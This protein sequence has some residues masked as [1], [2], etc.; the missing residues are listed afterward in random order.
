MGAQ[1][2][3]GNRRISGGG[4]WMGMGGAA[5]RFISICNSYAAKSGLTVTDRDKRRPAAGLSQSVTSSRP[6]RAYLLQIEILLQKPRAE[7]RAEKRAGRRHRPAV[8]PRTAPQQ[9]G[10]GPTPQFRTFHPF[11][12]SSSFHPGCPDG[13]SR[14]V[15]SIS[16]LHASP[17]RIETDLANQDTASRSHPKPFA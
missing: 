13:K 4:G 2:C 17:M 12:D 7:A 1:W 9:S 6:N 5:R 10:R 11:S 15:S 16:K 14:N 3:N 8:I